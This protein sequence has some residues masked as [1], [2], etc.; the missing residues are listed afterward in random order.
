M[1]SNSSRFAICA[2]LL[3]CAGGC[4]PANQSTPNVNLGGYPPAFREGYVDGCNTA[5]SARSKAQDEAR[6]KSDS[7]YA[8]GWRDGR[9]ICAPR[10]P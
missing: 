10:K 7:M 8:A 9:D 5:R 6:L 2:L 3:A 4:A 1:T